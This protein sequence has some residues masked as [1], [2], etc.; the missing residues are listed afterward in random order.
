[1]NFERINELKKMKSIHASND[2]SINDLFLKDENN[3]TFFEYIVQNNIEIYD[4]E[5]VKYISN[6][7]DLL[8]YATERKYLLYSYNDSDMLFTKIKNSDITFI[9]AVIANK[10]VERLSLETINKLFINKNGEYLITKLLNYD[11]WIVSRIIRKINHFDTL[12]KCLKNIGRIDLMRYAKESLLFHA[13]KDGITA[14]EEL[15]NLNIKIDYDEIKDARIADILYKTKRYDLMLKLDADLLVSYPDKI[16]NYLKMLVVKYLN[17]EKIPFEEYHIFSNNNRSAAIANILLLKHNI[18]YYVSDLT[19]S[20]Q[21]V[22]HNTKPVFMYMLEFDRDLTINTFSN[23]KSKIVLKEYL[24]EYKSL[25]VDDVN[26]SN[27]NNYLPNSSKILEELENDSFKLT[28]YYIDDLVRPLSDGKTILDYVIKKG[29]SIEDI[30]YKY[31][32][33]IDFCLILINNNYSNFIISEDLLYKDIGD[34][35]KLI[36]LLFEKKLYKTIRISTNHDFRI[37]D[38]CVKY[39]NFE[40]ISS[41]IIDELFLDREDGPLANKYIG[42]RSFL[43]ALVDAKEDKLLTEFNGFTLLEYMIYNGINPTFKGYDFESLKTLKILKKY[44]RVDLLYNAKLEI[45]MNFPSKINNYL[46]Y[47][48]DSY[49]TGIDVHFEKRNYKSDDKELLART[50]IQMAE[51][52]LVVFLNVLTEA[53]LLEAGKDGKNI[54]YY[55][56]QMNYELTTNKIIQHSVL[57]RPKVFSELRILGVKDTMID[58]DYDKLDCSDI[59]RQSANNQYADS[60]VSPVENLLEELKQLFNDG[61]SDQKIIEA[62]ITSYRYSTSVNELMI[63]ELV[64]LIEI[65]KKNPDFYY[66]L[67]DRSYFN[68]INKSIVLSSVTI[69]TINHETGHALHFFLANSD[70]PI[71]IYDIIDRVGN[72]SD[73]GERVEDYSKRF[74]KLFDRVK[75]NSKAA[76]SEYISQDVVHNNTQEISELLSSNKEKITETYIKRGY[77]KE[78]LDTVFGEPF[79]VEEFVEQKKS[80]EVFE[81]TDTLMRYKYDAF[82]A[83]GDIL[84]GIE[85]GRFRDDLLKNGAGETIDGAYGHGVRYY[86]RFELIFHEMVA[87]YSEIIK[88]KNATEALIYLRSLVGDELVDFLE[89]FYFGSILKLENFVDSNKR[90]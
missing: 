60:I 22:Y 70:V 12:Y 54:L 14:F 81:M 82:I 55:L 53:E 20:I 84:D 69:S 8:S 72:I 76:I 86:S 35:K 67:G 1:M 71:E 39:D 19:Y 15:L 31:N 47:M 83:I 62:L 61:H 23:D 66:L 88:S 38:Y 87:E 30:I 37:L 28:D 43:E 79:T 26:L 10:G 21:D 51:N 52:G 85:R 68:P 50:Y 65:K 33:N 59:Y 48:I 6:N 57:I 2:V 24:F 45:L 42:I 56:T 29:V 5:L 25:D 78:V 40:N 4:Q 7:Y 32:D 9:E 36:D 77:S 74:Q 34:N 18:P 3:E 64:K 63:T 75:S 73:F 90:I 27:I 16:H 49:K 41:S 17:G 89:N 46:Q 11:P 80:I 13:N 58:I 44:N